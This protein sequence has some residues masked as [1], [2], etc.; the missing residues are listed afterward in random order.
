MSDLD[1]AI[2][3]INESAAK[4]ENTA[5]FLDDMSTFD[6]QSSVTNPNNGQTVASIPKQVKD[7]TDELFSAA[8]SDINQAVAT[9][10]QN[11]SDAAQ[12]ASDASESANE[13]AATV[14]TQIRERV[15]VYKIGNI[16]D[17]AGQQLTGNE[18][19]NQYQ[20]PDNSEQWYGA[21]D[22][23]TFPITIPS[24]PS[25]DDEWALVGP[26]SGDWG[27]V[28]VGT[29]VK[30]RRGTAA[31]IAAGTPAI[32]ELWFNTT[33]NYTHMG[34]GVTQGGIEQS[35]TIS[36]KNFGSK[37][38]G[39]A[40]DT[41]SIVSA[42]STSK[43]LELIV[44]TGSGDHLS[45]QVDLTNYNIGTFKGAGI[46][47]TQFLCNTNIASGA[48]V[49]LGF[50]TNPTV[51]PSSIQFADIGGFSV[52]TN[53][54]NI[55][56]AVS[57]DQYRRGKLSNVR[58][59][60]SDSSDDMENG[61][62]F[63]YSWNARWEGLFSSNHYGNGFELSTLALNANTFINPTASTERPTATNFFFDGGNTVVMISPS[64]EG[65]PKKG[66]DFG[67]NVRSVTL[68]NPHTEGDN[69]AFFKE[70]GDNNGMSINIIG[71]ASFNAENA[72]NFTGNFENLTISGYSMYDLNSLSNLDIQINAK[73]TVITN[74]LVVEAITKTVATD[75][76]IIDAITLGSNVESCIVNGLDIAK[77]YRREEFVITINPGTPQVLQTKYLDS[78]ARRLCNLSIAQRTSNS[79]IRHLNAT[80]TVNSND[81]IDVD[82]ITERPGGGALVIAYD[83]GAKMLT[84]DGTVA[85]EAKIIMEHFR[86]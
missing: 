17:Y 82:T 22:G 67:N 29:E 30:H 18:K 43:S 56:Y 76:Q 85:G 60:G 53:G 61:Y 32:G 69:G 5:G 54:K 71:G 84:V 42:I 64:S 48:Y 23:V 79:A 15:G 58:V 1:N 86:P 31:E 80:V 39:I 35:P 74:L 28:N 81:T 78:M 20:Y 14:E 83:T 33:L 6:D 77:L 3:S 7:R 10:T 55:N 57:A 25:I 38:D 51:H 75:R 49:D 27:G 8:E 24:D 59:Y 46:D 41:A 65:S 13:A 16:S 12:S 40:N 63:N 62:K 68:L 34:N 36:L 50:D 2:K 11:A 21:K 47:S 4:A 70:G 9:T 26:L 37:G 45:D 66:F 44:S 72:L 52:R 73:N 19:E